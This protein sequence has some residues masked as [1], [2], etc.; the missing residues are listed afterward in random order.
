MLYEHRLYEAAP[1]KLPALIERFK[2]GE[3]FRQ[4]HGI[5]LVGMWTPVL[6]G[7]S[8]Q[9]VSLTAWESLQEREERWGAFFADPA[10]QRVMAASEKDGPLAEK[11]TIQIWQPTKYSPM[12]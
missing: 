7:A 6:G 4:K 3:P 1:G 5:R 8:N 2:A 10:W 12:Q 9:L 11:V